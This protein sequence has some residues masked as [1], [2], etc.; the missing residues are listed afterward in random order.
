MPSAQAGYGFSDP[1]EAIFDFLQAQG[2]GEPKASLKSKTF[3]KK[4]V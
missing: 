1:G 2:E 3:S 4:Y